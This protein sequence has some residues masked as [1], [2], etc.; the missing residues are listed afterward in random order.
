M[1]ATTLSVRLSNWAARI[2]AFLP[3]TLALPVLAESFN[4][5][6]C[7]FPQ[8]LQ[9]NQSLLIECEKPEPVPTPVTGSANPNPGTDPPGGGLSPQPPAASPT[10]TI[11]NVQVFGNTVLN[12]AE[13]DNLLLPG[14]GQPVNR[15]ELC[16]ISGQMSKVYRDR[17]YILAQVFPMTDRS[18]KSL[19]K[20]GLVRFLVLEG[21]LESINIQGTQR[22]KP[23]YINS[24][25][26]AGA[27]TP[28]N[29]NK[30]NDYLALIQTDPKLA[31]LDVLGFAPGRSFGS[32]IFSI[33][34]TEANAL[35]GFVGVD[36]S[37][38]PIFGG[39]RAIGGLTYRNVTGNG[40]DLS[41]FYFRSTTGEAQGADF[42]YQIPVNA[43]NGQIQIRYAPSITSVVLQ[44]NNQVFKSNV[45]T[46]ELNYRQPLVRTANQEF[47]LSVGLSFQDQLVSL[48]GATANVVAGADSD[49]KTR[50]RVVQ[51]AQ[52]YNS[53]DN[54]GNWSLRSQFNLGL[55]A[56]DATINPRPTADGKFFS[57]QAQAQR[58]QRFSPNNYAIAQFGFQ[59]TPDPLLSNQQ[60]TLGGDRSIL[61]YRQNL[62]SSDNGIR[63]FLEDRTIVGRNSQ[64]QGNLQLV[65]NITA[66]QLWNNGSAT[67]DKG[68]LA[69]VGVGAI[70]EPFPRLVTRLDYGI[71]LVSINDRGN[72]FQDSG[73]NFSV[74]YGF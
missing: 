25:I 66:A 3:A 56:F 18:T 71:P 73:F 30:I 72:S 62:R 10:L 11:D 34:V 48:G 55:G 2:I 9:D 31:K 7:P 69:S 61:G 13:I 32:S 21:C 26:A 14:K 54:G 28:F 46:A 63:L 52:E 43:M 4:L 49:G 37:I 57:W 67:L 74:G 47:A 39:T 1:K 41:A 22:L 12:Q 65:G 44:P 6:M 33:K 40:D 64:G 5:P 19:N 35:T 70:W 36:A 29:A 45:S 17:G 50:T 59:L 60:F 68:F 20:D 42:S 8:V 58:V 53:L 15:A 23:N 51:F 24:R 16:K 38:A 27:A